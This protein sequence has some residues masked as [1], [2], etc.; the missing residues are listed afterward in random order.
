MRRPGQ[1]LGGVGPP[2]RLLPRPVRRAHALVKGHWQGLVVLI[3]V[4]AVGVA[5]FLSP[6]LVRAEAH[7]EGG[8][9]YAVKRDT[10][11]VGMVNVAIDQLASA[12]TVADSQAEVLQHE[13]TV[14]LHLPQ[15]SRISPYDPARNTLGA[16]TQLPA[17]AGL[18][19]VGDQLLVYNSEN[20]KLW[21]GD[22]ATVL[23]F[24]FQ[25]QKADLEI[26]EHGVA[27]LTTDGAVIGLDPQ[28]SALVRPEGGEP[29]EVAL[30]FQV[31]PLGEGVDISAVGDRAVVLDRSSG[32]IW[33]EGMNSAFDVSGAGSAR[34]ASPMPDALGGEGGARAIYATLAGLIAVTPDG[35]RSLTGQ[36]DATPI[37]PVQV[38]GCVYGAFHA[39]SG[40]LTWA[41]KCQ[42][43][44]VALASLGDVT[45]DGSGLALQVNRGDVA[46][47]DAAD[48]TIWL[49][50]QGDVIAPADWEAVTRVVD[51]DATVTPDGDAKAV[52]DRS[53]E[54]RAPTASDDTVTAR[55][56]RSTVLP[57][58]DNDT[59]PDGDVLRIS[60]PTSLDGATLEPVAS[61]AG[62]QITLPND[63]AGTLS[64]RYTIDDG[65]GGTDSATAQVR[66]VGADLA[67]ENSAPEQL[68]R[69]RPLAVTLGA[70]SVT[71]RALLDWR[72]PEGDPLMLVSAELDASHDDLVRF[73]ADGQITYTD[74]GKTVGAKD[75]TVVV[76]DGKD[77]ATGTVQVV[78][79]EEPAS[80][81]AHGDFA[82]GVVAQPIRVEPLD[83]D[84]GSEL[85]LSE[86]TTDCS[87]CTLTPNY[88]ARSFSFA[89]AQPGTY[90]VTYTVTNG[91]TSTGV[92]RIDVAAEG[93]N[94][95]PVA[96]LDVALLPP[97]GSVRID[98][99]LNDTDPDGD[100]LVVQTYTAPS[101]LNVVL[102]RRHLMTI[103][104]NHTP[105]GPLTVTYR[106]SDGRH[107]VVGTVVV[108]PAVGAG[109]TAPLAEDDEVRVRAGSAASIDVLGNDSSPLG[110]DLSVGEL[111]ENPLG[112]R[113]WTDG[114]RVRVTVP[115]GAPAGTAI[116]SY[117]A[118]DGD[119]S[120]TA[121]LSVTVVTEEA[122]NEAPTPIPVIDRVLAGTTTRIPIPLDG[123]DPNG[124]AVRLVGLGAGPALGRVLD[125]GERYLTYEAYP[126]SL[127]TDAF[128]YDVVDS[129]GSR[130]RGE[131]RVGVAQPSLTN[132]PP[133]AMPDEVTV[134]PGRVAQVAAL[135]NDFDADGDTLSFASEA[136]MDG[137][138]PTEV[139]GGRELSVSTPQREG[140]YLGS[141]G[142][143]DRRGELARGELRIVVDAEAP[144]LAPVARDDSVPVS[145]LIGRSWVEVDVLANDFDP[146]GVRSQLR[147]EFPTRG[148]RAGAEPQVKGDGPLVRVPV[149]ERMQQIRYEVVDGDGNRS[150]ALIVVPGREDSV[151]VLTDPALAL[152]AVAGRPLAIDLPEI[153]AGT[154]GRDVRLTTESNLSA[155]H[156]RLLAGGDRSLRFLPDADYQGPAS[157][158]FEVI[159]VAPDASGK[160]AFVSIPVTVTRQNEGDGASDE[161]LDRLNLPPVLVVDQPSLRVGPDEGEESLSLVSLFRDPEGDTLF[162]GGGLSATPTGGPIDWRLDGETLRAHAPVG[163]PPGASVRLL[164]TMV[165]ANDNETPF[166]VTISVVA[167]TRPVPTVATDTVSQAA[168]GVPVTIPVLANDRSHLLHDTTLHLLGVS[169]LSGEGAVTFDGSAGT[170]TVTP[171]AGWH[172]PL[173][174]SY[175]VVD[176]TMASDRRVDGI[177]RV[178]V[179][180][181]PGRPSTP[182][183]AVAGDGEAS[184][185]YLPG[186]DG[187]SP[188]TSRV[189]TA[190]SPGQQ[191]RS[192]ECGI[193]V[194]TVT[195]LRN[196]VGWQISVVESNTVGPSEASPESASVTPDAV[197]LPPARPD[198]NSGDGELTI[199]W[200]HDPQYASDLGGSPITAYVITLTDGEGAAAPVEVPGD[201]RR[202]T[203]RGLTNGTPYTVTV[204]AQ[205]SRAT[206][207]T[208]ARSVPQTPAGL[209]R[210]SVVPQ[211]SSISDGIGGG[212]TV[213]FPRAAVDD[214]GSAI[215]SF[216][217]TP[218]SASGP[219]PDRA[220][221]VSAPLAGDVTAEI[222]G[223]G[224]TPVTFTVE[225]VNGVG[226]AAV[227]GTGTFQ[228]SYPLPVISNF[229][230]DPADGALK[231]NATTNI[232]GAAA[233]LEYRLAGGS[234]EQLPG[235][236][237]IT[238]LTNGRAYDVSV[239]ARVGDQ[240]S[241]A[242]TATGVRPR[243]DQPAPPRLGERALVDFSRIEVTL[244]LTWESTGGWD[245]ARYRF[246]SG[247]RCEPDGSGASRAFEPGEV[248]VLRWAYPDFPVSSITVDL[249]GSPV[250]EPRFVGD[251]LV[252]R[253]PYVSA[254]SC[255]VSLDNGGSSFIVNTA[256]GELYYRNNP[257]YT[258]GTGDDQVKVAARSAD[259]TCT[260]G[261]ETL[262]FPTARR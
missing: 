151:P 147:V 139:L 122:Q 57:I 213:S 169:K 176:A 251:D 61:G 223:L 38:A 72:D 92:V 115:A 237:T 249:T 28:R 73:T 42:G 136:T 140:V 85:T 15:S 157:V 27:T 21:H 191:S 146:D 155:T 37:A 7:L 198:V 49:L 204:A 108:I 70:K 207:P 65:R 105:E 69:A 44:D 242:L 177:I 6:G 18:Q 245:P 187:G 195:G 210:G 234:W 119:A 102:D 99:L 186:D 131:I 124:D 212:F 45:N 236:R 93:A 262:A 110:L 255:T 183:E 248:G 67:R 224:Q 116:L 199:S 36:L 261:G 168:A 95:V 82:T 201:S 180:D 52:P 129:L 88:R 153:I 62:L 185:K 56:G 46:L 181:R 228:V 254:G 166:A 154:R 81:I 133:V 161:D 179:L 9:V 130:A 63:A 202:Y 135:A 33:V 113:A 126:E 79:T 150:S 156:G 75:I 220:R 1:F 226:S 160:A 89:S 127:G 118:V 205:N 104:S 117:T 58:L 109:T 214:N 2:G 64:F 94:R 30:P 17:N 14:L 235:N 172:G 148:N 86:V 138:L 253:F 232:D 230:V 20:G 182:F 22:V 32:L 13:D 76:S 165:D 144:L 53:E 159:D 167:S 66:V 258:S 55:A 260:V 149:L 216:V 50:D 10:G 43:K 239:R 221:T 40:D 84:V 98:P 34:L 83:N 252:F 243:S 87:D 196:G 218:V 68:E 170:V 259:V 96:A 71:T 227:G 128:A 39:G 197:P 80:P 132:T 143:V 178:Q 41:K 173:V 184:V 240:T 238:G 91:Q 101:P 222:Y 233:S 35:P 48:G 209:P 137:A 229:S 5:A 134:R 244:E 225:A 158:V 60:A 193:G 74:V 256:G 188:V 211:V 8:T 24:D 121:R 241:A 97:G 54:N 194:C 47:N 217:V 257:T 11:L 100:V 215:S 141:Y 203:W 31:D 106:V 247:A 23:G 189:A 25:R 192:A 250:V 120:G 208:S 26:G 171:A 219:L 145:S 163:A 111:T 51:G 164:G 12:A 162:L 125:V 200:T 152:Q 16:L 90:Y 246:C 29:R 78:V 19:L 107:S 175:T 103:T 206:S 77:Q 123:I 59:D 112:S 142:I 4:I 190:T 3:L 114:D 174:A 231:V